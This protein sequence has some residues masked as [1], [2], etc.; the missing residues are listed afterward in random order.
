PQPAAAPETAPDGRGRRVLV[1][2]D[3]PTNQ[4]VASLMLRKAGYM[5]TVVEDGAQAVAACARDRYDIVLMDVQMPVMDGMEA[6]RRIRAAEAA[7]GR[8]RT[9]ILA[10]TANAMA[11]MSADYAAAGMDDCVY[12]PFRQQQILQMVDDWS[13]AR[14]SATRMEAPAPEPV[15]VAVPEPMPAAANAMTDLPLLEEG[16]L[17]R[18]QPVAGPG[19]F[20]RLVR[21]FI[22]NG[23]TRVDRVASLAA[24][25]DR[26]DLHT[27]G[28]QAHDLI[29]TA[30]NCGLRRLEEAAR[31]LQS[32]CDAGDTDR[33]RALGDLIGTIGPQS[34]RAL[35]RRFLETAD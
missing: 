3:N 24:A 23:A 5:V 6:T 19:A 12:K 11:G 33:A 28:Q 26:T 25:G 27:L 17:G 32:A 30:G 7:E 14:G 29:S 35:G 4:A 9:P 13:R 34:W 16:V 2:E 22:G 1:V 8:A 18:L 21:D 10:M 15:G 20:D 31:Q